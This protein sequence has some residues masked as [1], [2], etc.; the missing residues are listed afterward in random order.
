MKIKI[1]SL[2]IWTVNELYK[3]II[4][5]NAETAENDKK[6]VRERLSD[7]HYVKKMILI[8]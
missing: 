5:V 7:F 6:Y 4:L 8:K 2:R 1:H 3:L